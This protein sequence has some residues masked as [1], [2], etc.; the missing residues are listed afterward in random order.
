MNLNFAMKKVFVKLFHFCIL[1]CLE[2]DV[3]S[4]YACNTQYS[5]NN[6]FSTPYKGADVTDLISDVWLI[7]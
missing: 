5:R 4:E 2:N 6:L 3:N 7:S 1:I